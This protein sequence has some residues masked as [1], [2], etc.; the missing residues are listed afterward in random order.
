MTG[1]LFIVLAY[2]AMAIAYKSAEYADDHG[3]PSWIFLLG[4]AA[5]SGAL[6]YH[7]IPLLAAWRR[8]P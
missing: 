6:L 4:F 5:L 2:G 7:G 8:T 1:V 3:W